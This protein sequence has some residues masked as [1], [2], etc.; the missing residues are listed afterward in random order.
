[1][2][3]PILQTYLP[4]LTTCAAMETKY[5]IFGQITVIR[6]ISKCNSLMRRHNIEP[7]ILQNLLE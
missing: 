2:N 4:G 1:M 6:R 7:R 5:N 3:D